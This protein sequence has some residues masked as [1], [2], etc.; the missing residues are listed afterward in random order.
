[1]SKIVST[2]KSKMKMTEEKLSN[3]LNELFQ[4]QFLTRNWHEVQR[5]EN[6]FFKISPSPNLDGDPT[7]NLITMLHYHNFTIWHH[8][9][10]CRNDENDALV[11]KHK[12]QIDKHNQTRND[13]VE[14][15]DDHLI[16]NQ[17]GY[18]LINSETIGSVIDRISI[19]DLKVYHTAELISD[20][21]RN[22]KLE[23]RLEILNGQLKFLWS[24]AI[25]LYRDMLHGHRFVK[26]FRQ[27]KTYN[28]PDLN[29]HYSTKR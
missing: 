14:K 17:K 1:M 27:L 10:Y 20:S 9:D 13:M 2:Q 21:V 28:N 12:R 6:E 5:T 7:A 23:M 18:G 25:A 22:E 11:A 24:E 16:Q 3:I 26:V 8:E 15:I 29:P 19:T 4:D